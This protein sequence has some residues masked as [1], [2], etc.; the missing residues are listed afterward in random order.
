MQIRWI[1]SDF[2]NLTISLGKVW[3]NLDSPIKSYD[4]LKFGFFLISGMPPWHC[5]TVCDV[6]TVQLSNGTLRKVKKN[7]TFHGNI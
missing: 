6:T 1:E 4:L 5:G 2:K 7:L 3:E